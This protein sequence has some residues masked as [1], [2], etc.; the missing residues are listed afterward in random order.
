MSF[1]T[2]KPA[3]VARTIPT[4]EP[5]ELTAG[6][7]WEWDRTDLGPDYLPSD[8]WALSY[9]LSG[10]AADVIAINATTS[11]SG[12][13]FE[14]R[15]PAATTARYV[16]GTYR[17]VGYVTKSPDRFP[18]FSGVLRVLTNYAVAVPA[19]SNDETTL[20]AI[21]AAV[22]G[23]LTADI[24]EYQ[25]NGRAVKK[26]PMAELVKLQGIYRSRVARERNGGRWGKVE[27]WFG[28]PS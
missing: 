20:A 11:T 7:S 4:C 27:V 13:Y 2:W 17:L 18:A 9:A 14:V 21:E 12:D 25:I 26:I 23:R 1:P 3:R 28:Q 16:A 24:E 15:V 22:S 19:L 6:D 5:T 10:A 8:G